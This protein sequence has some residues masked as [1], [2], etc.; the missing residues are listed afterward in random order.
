MAGGI[1][2]QHLQ[3]TYDATRIWAREGCNSPNALGVNICLWESNNLPGQF[4][5]L[6]G[7]AGYIWNPGWRSIDLDK[8]PYGERSRGL[9]SRRMKRWQS[10][11]TDADDQALRFD[12]G[13]EV[14]RG[15]YVDGPLAG[16]SVT[17]FSVLSRD[18]SDNSLVF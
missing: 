16:K 2:S 12:R 3:G 13:W 11:I 5:G 17:P 18:R 1:S 7:G 4:I 10:A 15:V 9:L 6:F 14:Y 8:D